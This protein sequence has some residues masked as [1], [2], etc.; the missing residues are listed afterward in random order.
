MRN[1]LLLILLCVLA[2][3]PFLLFRAFFPADY[4]LFSGEN[5]MKGYVW[6]L[7]T[8]LFVHANLTHLI[9]NIIFLYAFGS[10]VER[11]VGPSKMAF[12]FFL[13]GIFSFILSL[14]F[15]GLNT[16]MVGASAAIFTLAAIAMLIR[17]LKFCWL[18]FMPL[19]LA[20]I[21]FFLL[22]IF[23]MLYAGGSAVGYHAHVIG[24]L[25]GVP[26]GILWSRGRWKRNLVITIILLVVYLAIIELFLALLRI[27][28]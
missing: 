25:I 2:T 23:L 6:T 10:V 17:P 9:G 8:S 12:A 15:Y 4:L 20:A 27:T 7:I 1:T 14:N 28:F 19:G 5:L 16:V 13:G 26:L 3:I 21:L 22:N 18:I 24:F 11:E